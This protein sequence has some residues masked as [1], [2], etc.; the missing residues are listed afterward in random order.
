MKRS[1]LSLAALALAFM[2]LAASE[3]EPFRKK[4]I[5]C[6]WDLGNFSFADILSNKAA[7]AA[8]PFDGARLY[9]NGAKGADGSLLKVG[10]PMRGAAWPTDVFDGFVPTLREVTAMWPFRHSFLGLCISSGKRT[11]STSATMRRGV[12]R[13]ATCG[14][15]RGS[16]GRAD[17][18]AS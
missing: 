5:A 17:A 3:T 11:G 18:R 15:S 13:S 12:V 8:L 1:V 2:S 7:F 6:S 14:S 10:W 9:P 4:A 16:P